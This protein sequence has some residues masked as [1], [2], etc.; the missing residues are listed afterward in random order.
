LDEVLSTLREQFDYVLIDSSPLFAADDA[1]TLAPKV[2]GTILVV[3]SSVSRTSAVRE[4]LDSLHQR[5]ARVLGIIFNGANGSS[6]SY[7][8]YKYAEYYS[9][10]ANGEVTS[11]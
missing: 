9:G 4:A 5:Q 1:A 10:R 11:S 6:N 2:D 3:R 8:Y 7:Q